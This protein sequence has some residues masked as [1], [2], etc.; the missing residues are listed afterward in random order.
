[1]ID[2]NDETLAL[3]LID[4]VGPGGSFIAEEH[5][6]RHFKEC[7]YSDLFDR[8]TYERWES[9][10]SMR[11]SDRINRN[12]IEILEKHESLALPNEVARELDAMEQRWK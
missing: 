5:T 11:L 1:G 4:K 8:G 6:F 3:D 7:W 10:G 12:V 2:I 9:Q